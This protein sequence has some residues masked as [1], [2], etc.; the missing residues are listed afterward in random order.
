MQNIVQDVFRI[1]RRRDLPNI[2]PSLL[3]KPPPQIGGV[4][5]TA[6][7]ASRGKAA[8]AARGYFGDDFTH[9]FCGLG[10]SPGPL[11]NRGQH[12]RVAA[13]G[14]ICEQFLAATRGHDAQIVSIGAGFDTRFWQLSA[15]GEAPRLFV[16]L[17]QPLIVARKSAIIAEQPAL[18]AALPEGAACVGAESV[19]S[20]RYQLR[21][22]DVRDS[23]QL[24]KALADAGWDADRP[25]LVLLECVLVYLPPEEA[26]AVL[27]WF[28]QRSARVVLAGYEQIKPGDAFGRTML[29]NLRRRDCPLL[30]LPA[31]PE[32][33][34]QVARCHAAGYARAEA[35]D[36]LTYH[37]TVIA[38]A[39]RARTA[40]LELLDEV[41]E[42]Q[43]LMQHYCVVMAVR[44][45]P[46]TPMFGTL[47]LQAPVSRPF[48]V[49]S[50]P[51]AHGRQAALHRPVSPP[52]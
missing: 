5:R 6:Y 10:P 11:I 37:G 19:A 20:E 29:E 27:T 45:V 23:A 28:S 24:G 41:E 42:W 46:E 43:M 34:S 39:E 30:G 52:L 36:L 31:C 26:V 40:S 12:V 13:V 25:T 48:P 44:D 21:A 8:A 35:L 47:S 3:Q 33:A 7:D 9:H 32:L 4:E 17:D 51:L 2:M 22:A 18:L 49:S 16:E 38:Q 50:T 14:S 15:T 1:A